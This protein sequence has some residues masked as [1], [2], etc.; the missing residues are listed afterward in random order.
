MYAPSEVPY[1]HDYPVPKAMT[2]AD[3]QKVEDAFVAAVK[4]V[5]KIGCKYLYVPIALS[6]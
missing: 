3:L 1:A 5:D 2:E 6:L 4:R